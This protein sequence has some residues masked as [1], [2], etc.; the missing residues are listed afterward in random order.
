MNGFKYIFSRIKGLLLLLATLVV[1]AVFTIIEEP[2]VATF[3]DNDPGTINY[4]P[5]SDYE[6]YPGT[7]WY[8]TF[9][10]VIVILYAAYIFITGTQFKTALKIFLAIEIVSLLD[11]LLFYS[12][13][14]FY[15]ETFPVSWNVLKVAFFL[16][17]I[18][19]EVLLLT[20]QK[21]QNE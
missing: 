21:L 10:H 3:P 9:E 6:L 2:K 15:A 11:Y 16:L 13:I 4:F 5:F 20:E 8:F 18:A 12:E 7:F 19:N 14:W 17:A 1:S